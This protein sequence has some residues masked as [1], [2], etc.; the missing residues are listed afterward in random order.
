[1]RFLFKL[2]SRFSLD[3]LYLI[4]GRPIFDWGYYIL[5]WRRK[6][7]ADN[8]ARSFPEKSEAERA[9]I[10][11]ASYRNL[12]DL[13]SEIIWSYGATPAQLRERVEVLNPE[14]VLDRTRAGQSILLMTAHYCNWEWQVLAGNMWLDEPMFPVYKPQRFAAMDTFLREARGRF[15]GTPIPHTKLTREL[16]RRRSETHVYAMVADQTPPHN[17]PKYWTTFL[18]QDTAFFVGADAIARILQ[19]TVVFVEMQRV[20]RG[21]YTM[22]VSVIAEPPYERGA[23]TA[24]VERYARALESEIRSNPANWLWIH[25]KWKYPKPTDA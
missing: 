18:H 21:Y 14:V 1:M 23:S 20:R 6:L 24:I 5:R 11:K 13:I 25:R 2:L 22:K 4:I 7:A 17:D 9:A 8:I 10:L 15:G 3:A 12:A 16:L 19:A